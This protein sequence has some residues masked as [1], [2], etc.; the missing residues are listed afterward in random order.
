MPQALR[1]LLPVLAI[2][3]SAC[4]R[5]PEPQGAPD[6]A[7]G[8]YYWRTTLTLDSVERAFLADHHIRKMYVRFFDVVATSDGQLQ[9]NA[10]LRFRDTI[11][12]G[13]EVIPTVFITPDCLHHNPSDKARTIIDRMLQMCR[14][15]GIEGVRELQFDCDW[16]QSTQQTYFDLLAT[17]RDILHQQGL[18]MSVTIRLH[19]LALPS[20]P[21]DYGVLMM[22]NT[23]DA[24]DR[25][26]GNPI[27][28]AADIETYLRHLADY[29]LPLC[30]AYPNFSWNLLFHGE[31]FVDILYGI[32]LSDTLF[33]RP[34]GNG[35]F[36][37]RRTTTVGLGL[38][39]DASSAELHPGDEVLVRRAEPSVVLSVHDRLS[40][41]RPSI[42]NQV[43]IYSLDST[44]IC[45]FNSNDYETILH[46]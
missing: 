37:V 44:N 26:C 24:T 5:G 40:T 19:Q 11:P 39:E 14:T 29:D 27:L 18:R 6:P 46:P 15:N 38:S 28:S 36:V 3:L 2:L 32:D 9:P 30:A 10:T 7:N 41:L 13:I 45:Q 34:E 42:N 23:G 1:L 4:S 31:E 8:V 21:A 35:R 16:T 33:Y 22:Y 25:N 12:S 43:I 17:I 20:P